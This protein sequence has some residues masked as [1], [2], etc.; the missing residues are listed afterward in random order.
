MK[1]PPDLGIRMGRYGHGKRN[2]IADLGV[3]V[4]HSTIIEGEDIRTGVTLLLPPVRNPPYEE[5]LFAG[6]V[7]TFNGFSKPIG[8]VQIEELGYLETPIA[9]TSTLNGY[10]VA[11]AL[12]SLWAGGANPRSHLG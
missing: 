10:R 5:R 4:G 8:F 12:V 9:L 7:Y 3:K 6:G 11:D 2:S 1:A